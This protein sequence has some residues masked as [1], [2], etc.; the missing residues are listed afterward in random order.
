[1]NATE[2]ILTLPLPRARGSLAQ[3][4]P[5]SS[6]FPIPTDEE[7][8]DRIHHREEEALL[9][10]FRRYGHLAFS[11]GCRILRDEGEAEDLVQEVF[12]RL[13]RGQS[14]FD[15][16]KGCA[17]TWMVQMIYRRALDRRA[18]LTRRQFFAGTDVPEHANAIGGDTSFEERLIERL[19]I[20]QLRTAFE[21]LN[22]KQRE[23][24]ELF[25]FEGLKFKEISERLEEDVSNIRH[26]YY[27]GLRCL[28]QTVYEMMCSGKNS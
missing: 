1:M 27:R 12:L 25:F 13:H 3:E 20:Q 18:Y 4:T 22:A 9:S 7:L 10:L 17:R 24:L 28:R 19:T 6:L 8:L 11:I 26:H 21:Y 2:R 5:E 14:S 15:S 16:T 23:T